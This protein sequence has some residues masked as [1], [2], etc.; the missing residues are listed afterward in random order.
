MIAPRARLLFLLILFFALTVVLAIFGLVIAQLFDL[1]PESVL[2]T[3]VAMPVAVAIGFWVYRYGGGILGPSIIGLV[4]LYGAVYVG[5]ITCRYPYPL[6][7]ALVYRRRSGC[8]P[9]R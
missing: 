4:V 6:R 9:T 3:W 5:R 8:R 7:G 1:Y 2:S